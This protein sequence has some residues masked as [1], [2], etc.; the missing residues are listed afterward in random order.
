M[1]FEAIPIIRFDIHNIKHSI[2]K[3]LGVEGSEVGEKIGESVE[4]AVREYDFD[5]QVK[6]VVDETINTT[7]E[8][9]FKYGKGQKIVKEAVLKSLGMSE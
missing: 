2:Q 3:Y 9:I 8:N 7:I 5:R 1:D 4:K 6:M